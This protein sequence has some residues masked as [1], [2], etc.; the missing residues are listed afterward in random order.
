M[1]TY[2]KVLGYLNSF[3]NYEKKVSFGYKNSFKLERMRFFLEQL[4][5]PQ[6]QFP[7]IH[8]CGTKGKGSTCACVAYLLRSLGFRVGLYT[9]PH[10]VD[11]RERIRILLPRKEKLRLGKESQR[12]IDDFEGMISKKELI[13]L[14][15][16]LRSKIE[17]YSANSLYG[18]LSFFEVYTAVAFSYFKQK[19]IDVAVL[20]T[21]LGGRL[22]ATNVVWPAVVGIT[23]I[24]YDH[25]DKLG[26]RLSEIAYE[27]AGIIKE[28]TGLPVRGSSLIVVSAPQRTSVRRVIHQRC[29]EKKATLYEIGKDIMI[30]H[31]TER[32]FS[33]KTPWGKFKDIPL[34]LRGEHQIIN[35]CLGLCLAVAYCCV[36]KQPFDNSLIASGLS[37]VRWPCRFEIFP[38][39]PQ[40]IIDGAH[41]RASA[42]ALK[43]TL[44]KYAYRKKIIFIIGI[45]KDKDVKGILKELLPIGEIY[46]MTKAANTRAIEP[47]ILVDYAKQIYPLSRIYSCSDSR[48]AYKL[49]CRN[50]SS[51]DIIVVAGSLFLA[52]EIRKLLWANKDTN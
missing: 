50:A 31:R 24:S 17:Y 6:D 37:Q 4:N 35:T 28:Q 14:V 40:V 30:T 23:S 19:K 48:D 20:E 47:Q 27:K 52:A 43:K 33:T 45:S 10:L 13:S 8:I 1:D 38:T 5:N 11:V 32:S 39:R 25:M 26:N 44:K 21:G 12:W 36:A 15:T 7:V 29:K 34:V 22:D 41:N 9:S 2:Q 42:E 49:A 16:Q 18:R 46:I 3:I 51:N